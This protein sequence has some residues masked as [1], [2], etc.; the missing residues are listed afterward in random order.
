[1]TRVTSLRPK[2]FKNGFNS[3]SL[4]KAPLLNDLMLTTRIPIHYNFSKVEKVKLR[5]S[6]DLAQCFSSGLQDTE[7]GQA[8]LTSNT[9]SF[10]APSRGTKAASLGHLELS[11][12]FERKMLF[13]K[14]NYMST[15]TV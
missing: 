7:N 12:I 8:L 4:T 1:M 15:S 2:Q 11:F 10:R 13:V 3:N 9:L 14:L 6:Q 5:L